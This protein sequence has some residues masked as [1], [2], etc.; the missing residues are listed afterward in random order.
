MITWIYDREKSLHHMG[1][2]LMSEDV[3]GFCLG[4]DVEKLPQDKP[5][6]ARMYIMDWAE[7]SD[8]QKEAIGGRILIFDSE[9]RRW[10][11]QN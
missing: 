9:N 2:E 11:P 6:A 7:L 1:D 3:C 8:A 10:L 4:A 5:N